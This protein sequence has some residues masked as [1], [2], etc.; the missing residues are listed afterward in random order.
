MTSWFAENTMV[1]EVKV[2]N[3]SK[4]PK[5]FNLLPD[6]VDNGNVSVSDVKQI[7]NEIFRPRSAVFKR[8]SFIQTGIDKCFQIDLLDISNEKRYNSGEQSIN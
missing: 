6:G 4:I 5:Y 8:S 3:V 1:T 2:A 7:I